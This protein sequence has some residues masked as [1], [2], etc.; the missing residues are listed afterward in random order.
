MKLP[1]FTNSL[2]FRLS[3][4]F[5][6]LLAVG[7][8]VYWVWISATILKTEVGQEEAD[9]F[10][11]E[12][13]E[14]LDLLAEMAGHSLSH[15]GELLDVL[16]TYGRE[17]AVY[18]V[19][20]VMFDTDGEY[21]A[22]SDPDSLPHAIRAVDPV[23]L[24][25]MAGEEWDYGIYPVEDNIDAFENRIFEVDRVYADADT[26]GQVVA[27]LTAS[28][29]PYFYAL[30]E[31]AADE[32]TLGY[33]AMIVLLVFAALS[34]LVIMTWASQRISRLS[35]D[36]EVFAGGQ[37]NRRAQARSRDEIGT[38]GR[39][40]NA[41]AERIETMVDK[42]KE[43]EQFQR[44]LIANVSHDLR[45][46]MA[47]MRG[48]VET[49][50]MQK[51]TLAPED[52]DR[53]LEIIASN[54]DHLDR[55]IDRMLVLSRF[56]A[57]QAQFQME[58][59][60]I[61][62]LADSV[63]QRCEHVAEGCNVT[64][65]LKTGDDMALVDADP[66]QVAQVLQN[67]VENGI[68]FNRP[69]G[70]VIIELGRAALPGS[71]ERISIAVHDTGLGIAPNDLPHIFERFYT[72]DKSRQ[73]QF[74]SP[75][76]TAA[77]EHLGQSSGLGLAIASKIVAGHGSELKVSSELGEGTMFSFDLA[78]ATDSAETADEA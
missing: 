46:P 1:H 53:Y 57:G 47:S 2:H 8:G 77:R 20:L 11:N 49:L 16:V 18:E 60:P 27:Y 41:M 10:A 50:Q 42:L 25:E 14:E 29:R 69:G 13:T 55:L 45:T 51:A 12:A 62:E 21:F 56:D 9:W 78:S 54:I 72:A 67:L 23:M 30:D 58:E 43:K 59:F 65:G 24:A 75:G 76:L 70:R 63:L 73:R 61:A 66:L 71:A 22:S 68:K 34:A 4:L 38:L 64:L 19:E 52:Q 5:M 74:D 33:G 37:L 39:Q 15:P 6:L 32:R 26:T 40:F 3:A 44:Q 7:A 36:V 17:V 35:R 48:F 31:L 28:Y